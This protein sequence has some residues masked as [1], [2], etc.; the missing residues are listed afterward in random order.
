MLNAAGQRLFLNAAGQRLFR[1]HPNKNLL[2]ALF[3]DYKAKVKLY[4][5]EFFGKQFL[6]G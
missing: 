5:H 6:P 1:V 4:Y 2:F 3:K